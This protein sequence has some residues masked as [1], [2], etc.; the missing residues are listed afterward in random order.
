MSQEIIE[1]IKIFG[2]SCWIKKND[3]TCDIRCGSAFLA[4]GDLKTGKFTFE[5]FSECMEGRDRVIY[6]KEIVLTLENY[7][8]E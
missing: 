4:A 2:N 7:Y 3:L 1:I 6:N 8:E 5:G